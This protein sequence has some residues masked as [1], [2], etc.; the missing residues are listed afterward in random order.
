MT[1]RIAITILLTVWTAIIIAGSA[2]WGVAYFVMLRELDQ[3]VLAQIQPGS[4]RT[5]AADG[6]AVRIA[7]AIQIEPQVDVVEQSF[8]STAQGEYRQLRYRAP[9]GSV[10]MVELPTANF[11]FTL[12]VLGTSL[13]GC[14][15]VAGL[16]AMLI[17]G[18]LARV[19]LRPLQHTAEVIGD[20]DE[21]KLDRRIV[22]D[23][24]PVELQPMAGRLNE[25]LERLGI[26]FEQ[27]RRFL[28]DASHE[29]RTPVAALI[30]TMEIALRRPREAAELAETL[31]TCLTEAR[32]MRVLVQALLRQV[33]S[34]GQVNDDGPVDIDAGQMLK[35]CADLADSLAIEKQVKVVRS[36]LGA[37]PIRAE[38]GR[39]RSVVLNLMS[40]AIEYSPPGATVE[41]SAMNSDNSEAEIAI[42]DNGPGIDPE[43]LPHIFQPF[44]RAS[45]HRE[46][47]GH[48][49]LG[50]FLVKSH[51][52]AM[53]GDCRVESCLGS[54]TTFRVRLP[55]SAPAL[56]T[57]GGT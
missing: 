20:I 57:N 24:L 3:A 9:D 30:T 55:S 4:V 39:L 32:H 14:G 54:G 8:V 17:A 11:R 47:E 27:R 25:L 53:G 50:L 1:R 40:N 35:E 2:A 18:R 34:E 16:G 31:R 52:R 38:V 5:T 46:S 41:V 37:V 28:A 21:S 22:A 43:H 23:E 10:P 19:A 7:K 12:D 33:R 15:L 44:Y 48:L 49:G 42:R 36:V 29:L 45:K 56:A 51:V 6:A 26:A 13:I